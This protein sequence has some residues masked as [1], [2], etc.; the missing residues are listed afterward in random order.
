[1][2]EILDIRQS[3]LEGRTQ[4]ALQLLDELEFMSRKSVIYTIESYLVRLVMHL[5]KADVEQRMT[6]SWRHSIR[7]SVLQIKALNV[8][9][10]KRSPYIHNTEWHAYIEEAFIH[11]ISAASVEIADGKYSPTEL[12]HLMHKDRINAHALDMLSRTY[13]TPKSE[14][15]AEIDALLRTIGG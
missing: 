6:N 3:I 13:T 14:L 10:N 9:D 15:A 8:M 12:E 4:D 5:I 11:S 7:D 1:M 2:Q